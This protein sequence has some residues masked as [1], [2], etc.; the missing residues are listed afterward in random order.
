MRGPGPLPTYVVVGSERH[1]VAR[2][3]LATARALEGLGFTVPV[4]HLPDAASLR[5]RGP[6]VT[7]PVHLDVTDGLFGGD[8]AEVP[9]LLAASLP[10][11][12]T[13]T[14][15]DVPQP[16]EGA[17]RFARRAG[18]YAEL[19]RW[20]LGT[21]V[22]SQH[23]RA[24]LGDVLAAAPGEGPGR[25]TPATGQPP[26]ATA[27]I[28]LPVEDL[29]PVASRAGGQPTD[30]TEPPPRDPE[31]LDGL[32]RDVVVFGFLYPGK[33]HAEALQALALLHA[34]GLA[35]PH[36][37]T[38]LGGVSDGHRDLVTDLQRQASREG[39]EFR[40]TGFVPDGTLETALRTA[41]IPVAAHHNVSASGSLTAW[42]SAGR[43]PIVPA[44]R[45]TREMAALRPGTLELVGPGEPGD[46]PSGSVTASLAAGIHRAL[47]DPPRTWLDPACSL[48]PGPA[49][50]ARQLVDFWRRVHG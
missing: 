9:G 10:G 18:A 47:A 16:A 1:G 12:A 5:E 48:R 31:P 29:R 35:A 24:L 23:E 25:G 50:S 32:A 44:S 43:R 34:Q 49:D 21:V 6:A 37:V 14:L 40:V 33:G 17:D 36:R 15:H 41:G 39:L 7:G 38:A 19:A 20:A 22:S 28:P 26:G 46:G 27:V 45:Y 11:G 3:A 30:P 2:H 13:L 42:M 8:P 4:V